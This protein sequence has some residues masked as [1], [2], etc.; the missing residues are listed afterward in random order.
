MT[1]QLRD[2][3]LGYASKSLA[4]AVAH[5]PGNWIFSLGFL[6]PNIA[7]TS[8]ERIAIGNRVTYGRKLQYPAN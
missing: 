8:T 5:P 7:V 2:T 4:A 3:T 1:T 6:K